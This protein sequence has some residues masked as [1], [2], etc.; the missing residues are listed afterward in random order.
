LR[1]SRQEHNFVESGQAQAGQQI[2]ESEQAGQQINESEQAD[3][4]ANKSEQAG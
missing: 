1:D 4:Q 3:Q 2:N